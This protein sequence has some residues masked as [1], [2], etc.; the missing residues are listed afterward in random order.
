M[1]TDALP[2]IIRRG[3]ALAALLL[4]LCALVPPA[5]PARGADPPAAGTI[6]V[7]WA[8]GEAAFESGDLDKALTLFST[9]L[10][11]DERR[12][13]S[14][15]YVGGVHFAQGDLPRALADF[16]KALELD[17]RDVRAWNNLGT[18]LERLGDFAG[19]ESAYARAVQVDPSYPI[20]QRNLGILQSRRL[21]NP[22]AA[23]RA[24]RRYLELS[25]TGAD[26]D[27]IRRELSAPATGLSTTAPA[28]SA[29]AVAPPVAR[30]VH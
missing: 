26:A 23:R 17:P 14:W 1:R 4:L 10:V 3:P 12:A 29:P 13:R 8:R 22:E 2:G 16:R 19:A 24:W 25:P 28:T 30:P 20:T 15:N 18:T 5:G 21:G 9:A 6:E 7:L 27:A 11:S